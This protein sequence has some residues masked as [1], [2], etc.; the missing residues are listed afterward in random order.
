MDIV[1]I[2]DLRI[3]AV[4]GV[5]E[6]EQRMR[7]TLVFDLE[8]GMDNRRAAASDRIADAI[9][10]GAV[11]RR[12]TALVDES[13]CQLVETLAERVAQILLQEFNV[14]WL[15]LKVNKQG[16]VRGVRDVGVIIER[17]ERRQ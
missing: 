9:D 8:L 10:Y 2:H 3:E 15:R 12:I 17:G 5:Y 7:Q 11:A 4:I 6:W 14:P 16:A 1:Y 13:R